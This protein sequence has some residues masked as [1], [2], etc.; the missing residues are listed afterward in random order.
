[1]KYQGYELAHTLLR[2]WRAQSSYL[3]QACTNPFNPVAY[4][5]FGRKVA[6]VLRGV[7]ERHP[8]LRQAGLGPEAD[9]GGRAAGA[10]ARGD[11]QVDP[12]LRPAPFRP[13]RGGGRQALRP[14]GAA[15]GA[16]VRPLRHAAA[17]HR[18][19][20]DPGAQSLHHRLARRAR[21]CRS[22]P[23]ASSSTNIIDHVIDFIRFLGSNTHVIA[24]CQPSVPVLAAAALMAARGRSLPPGLDHAD[25][26]PDRHQAQPD[27]GQ[28]A[29]AVAQHRAGSSRT[30]SSTCP[31][32][33]PA[34]CAG[35][36]RASSSSPAS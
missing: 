12:V 3:Q 34:S 27:R 8:A 19:G 15:G 9:L 22:W 4:T 21:R 13:R 10:G 16:D 5:S 33:T 6:A 35:S 24:V 23:V 20:D 18:R 28:R 36:I 32:R 26:R 31:G 1:M 30:S 7:R 11:R 2:P 29:R 14:Q 25:G 17:R